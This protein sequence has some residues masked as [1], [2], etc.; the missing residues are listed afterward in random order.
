MTLI[1]VYRVNISRYR[2]F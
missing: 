1:R 2:F